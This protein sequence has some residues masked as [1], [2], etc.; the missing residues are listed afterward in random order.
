MDR[1]VSAMHVVDKPKRGIFDLGTRLLHWSTAGFML[2]VFVFAFSIDFATSR[3]AHVEFLQLHRFIGL[4][5][6]L[7]TLFR[8]IWRQTVKYPDWP[9]D[10]SETRRALA[11][12]TEYA[13]YLLL[14]LQPILGLLQTNAHGDR[15]NLF[16]GQLPALIEKNRPLAEQ[17]LIVHKAVGFSL[18]GLIALHASAALFHHFVRRDEILTAML[19]A[20]AAWRC[21]GRGTTRHGVSVKWNNLD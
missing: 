3:A 6:W 11:K 1:G 5:V 14:L 15:V 9:S 17:L 13:L 2:C 21:S 4:A 18:L 8:L 16:L 10:M 7:L 20:A 19:P 12:A